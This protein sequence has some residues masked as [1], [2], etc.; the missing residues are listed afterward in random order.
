MDTD[1][2]VKTPVDSDGNNKETEIEEKDRV[3][4]NFFLYDLFNLE[5]KF[6]FYFWAIIRVLECLLM[7]RNYL[8][9]DEYWQGTEVAYNIVYG[10]VHLPWE[11]QTDFRL[12]NVIYPYY[13]ALPMWLAKVVGLDTP[14]VVRLTPYVAHSAIAV[15]S[16][17]YFYKVTKKL[18]GIQVARVTF[19][20]YFT[21]QFFNSFMIR[22]FSNSV[23]AMLHLLVFNYYLEITNKFD[24]NV[25]MVAFWLSIALGIRNTSIMAWVPLLIIK[26]IAKGAYLKFIYAGLFVALPAIAFVVAL[27][28]IYYGGLTF[29][30]WNFFVVNVLQNK[31]ADFGVHPLW[32]YFADAL[33]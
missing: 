6:I 23:E 31:S 3:R 30:A 17:Y 28:S 7:S 24:K 18:M 19:L 2:I 27:D 9:A 32:Y 21:N 15:A 26:M 4:S 20:Y 8:Y 10:G 1:Q 29:T 5:N 11:W 14:L 33:P 22:C 13:L 12:R 25:V 16:D